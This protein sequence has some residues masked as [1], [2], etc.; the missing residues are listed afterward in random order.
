VALFS[1]PDYLGSC[2][3]FEIGNYPDP[4]ALAG[5][6][7]N[8]LESILI[9]KNVLATL[10]SDASFSGRGETYNKSDSNIANDLVGSNQVSSFFVKSKTVSPSVPVG[11][12]FPQNGT[13][14]VGG[15]SLSLSWRDP[16][17]T[18][19]FQA[20]LV[21]PSGTMTSAW[22]NDPVW[23]LDEL[24]LGPGSY[25]WKVRARNCP[26]SSCQSAWSSTSSFNVS[27]IPTP[28]STVSAPLFDNV[29]NGTNGWTASGLWNRL[30]DSNIANSGSFAWYFGNPASRTYQGG[31]P[32]GD[33]TSRPIT[34][35]SSS[36]LLRFWYRYKTESTEKK[37]DQRWVQI[38]VDNGPYKNV[39]QLSDDVGDKWLRA[40]I[41]LS[42]YAGKTIRIRFHFEA[43]DSA[44]NQYPGWFLDD[45]EI[46][47]VALPGCK[48]GD[49]SPNTATTIT[50]DQTVSRVICPDGDVDY[51][52]FEGIAGDR[53]VADIDTPSENHPEDL[54]LILF[55]LDNDGRSVLTLHDDEETPTRLDPHLGY[56]LTRS[57]TYYLKAR[58]WSHPSSGGEDYTYNL[59]LSRDV[60]KPS[61][62]FSYPTSGDFIP[63][64]SSVTLEVS[65]SDTGSGISHVEFLYHSNDWASTDWQTLGTDK[66]SQDGWKWE[67]DPG[68]ALEGTDY[69]FY[70]NV[71]DWAGNWIG[72]GAWKIGLDRTPPNTT[73]KALS[74]TQ[75]STAVLI[76]WIGSDGFSGIDHFELQSQIGTSSWNDHSPAPA[77]TASQ[78]WFI[79]ASNNNYGFRLRGVDRAGNREDFPSTAETR[80]SIPNIA[81]LCSS[82]DAWDNNT[83][84]NSSSASSPLSLGSPTQRHNFCNPRT[85]DRLNDEDW[86]NFTVQKG[87]TYMISSLPVGVMTATELTLFASD[88]RT[89]IVSIEPSAFGQLT[90][91]IWTADRNGKVFLRNRHVD[92]RVAGNVVAY[93]LT[94]RIVKPL[95]FPMIER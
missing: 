51:F 8:E 29:E 50:Y 37:W 91:L 52:R 63:D 15:S 72:T 75:Q 85:L 11:L 95:F 42:N 9:G 54:D 3:L 19:A 84:D 65:A 20:Q 86:V 80:T 23:H 61:A 69:A 12:L 76:E 43:L 74:A 14:F 7:D 34:L 26:D 67:F 24:L 56:K 92:G 78:T 1:S 45:I 41:D 18:T 66:H 30:N 94:A 49:N 71:Y 82:P 44:L 28:P 35:S 33:L 88:G 79:A 57:G 40:T 62:D 59:H 4:S 31:T 81:T 27:A 93:D 46:S 25:T 73:L 32:S 13:T 38:S 77:G 89:E 2:A 47:A 68:L 6:G 21:G 64:S 60:Q 48:D 16:G 5:L 83:N 90:Q 10:F 87:Q 22:L 39:K 58:L 55:L 36:H 70:A 53:I 17:G